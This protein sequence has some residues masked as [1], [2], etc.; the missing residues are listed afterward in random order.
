MKISHSMI[1]MFIG[2]FIIQYF[3]MSPIM[4]DRYSNITN[5]I[6]KAYMATIMAL[7][8]VI[9]EIM[10]HDHQYGIMSFNWYAI[11]FSLI[12]VFIYLYRK[13]IAIN[14]KQYLEGMIEHHSMALLTSEEILKKT[15]NYDIAKL[16]KNII[17]TQND[18]LITMKEL[19][20]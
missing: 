10:M 20:K 3:L 15:D 7:S 8:M 14:D 4:V 16:A 11:L 6:G 18:E 19:V 5:S 2:S 13:Q 12:A 17:Q 1:V 9:I